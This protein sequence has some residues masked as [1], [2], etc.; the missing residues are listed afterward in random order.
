VELLRV[1]L[2]SPLA[3]EDDGIAFP[4]KVKYQNQA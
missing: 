3:Y 2:L 1:F 4:V